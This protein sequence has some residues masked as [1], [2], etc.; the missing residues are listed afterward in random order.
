M[1][2]G[3]KVRI[4]AQLIYAAEDRHLWAMD[5][6]N[7]NCATSCNCKPKSHPDIAGQIQ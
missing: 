2:S 3:G 1:R 5:A 7:A 4:T 6:T